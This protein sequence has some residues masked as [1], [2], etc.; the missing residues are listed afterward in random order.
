MNRRR[1]IKSAAWAALLP[2]LALPVFSAA[3]ADGTAVRPPVSRVRPGDP[4][5]PSA[6]SWDQ[7]NRDVGGRLIEVRWPL[8]ACHDDPVSMACGDLFAEL[9]NPYYVGDEVGLT[10]TAGW[11]DAWSAQ[12]SVFAVAAETTGDV[13][14]AVNFARENNLRLV[15]KGGGHSYLGTSNAPDSLLIWTRHMNSMA[16]HDTFVPQGCG[17]VQ[18]PQPAVTVG[19]GAVWMHVYNEVTTRGGRYVQG[20]GCLT[21]G[22]AGFVQVGGFGS[23]SKNYGTAAANLLEAEIVT[24]DGNVRI[25]NACTNPDLFW[26]LKGGGG[27]SFGV[28]TRLTLRTRELPEYFG[29]LFTTIR[30]ASDAAFRRLIAQF[31]AFYAT[32][33]LNPHWGDIVTLRRDNTLMVRMTFQGLDRQ[34][35][36][37]MWQPFLSGVIASGSDLSFTIAP[38]IVE[39][40][41]RRLWDSAYLRARNAVLIDDR[42]G[43][44]VENLFWAGNLGEAGHFLFGFESLW[45]PR[46]LLQADGRERLADALFAATRHWS[47]GLHFQKG[48]SGASEGTIS[49]AQDTATNPA[50]LDAFV[51]AIIAGGGPPAY[52]G[53]PDHQPDLEAGRRQAR[54]IG[55]AADELRKVA[56]DAGTYVAESSFFEREW[57]RAYWGPNYPKLLAIKKEY[58]PTGLFFAHHGVGS[59]EWSADGFTRLTGP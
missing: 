14:A 2:S 8:R 54:A 38:R 57:Q 24:A 7:L 18:A 50:V 31:I 47:V 44:P 4:A 43:A 15:V 16:L 48:L 6:A 58:D 45:L 37:A 20:G 34:Q 21:I 32:N 55:K 26:A 36:H 35:V 25:A 49:A 59:E 12:P 27:G 30:A 9:K 39:I 41:A 13:V 28:V 42:P 1:L 40:P 19:A 52:P 17:A 56:P 51:L 53:L 29:V 5:W 23:F 10:Q 3:S 46:S 33:L 11:L 22:I